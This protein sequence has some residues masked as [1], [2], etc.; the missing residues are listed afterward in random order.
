[1]FCHKTHQLW[2]SFSTLLPAC[3]ASKRRDEFFIIFLSYD[4]NW[5]RLGCKCVS[6]IISHCVIAEC[7]LNMSKIMENCWAGMELCCVLIS[8][9]AFCFFSSILRASGILKWVIMIN[10]SKYICIMLW[11]W[12]MLCTYRILFRSLPARQGLQTQI[13]RGEN[14]INKSNMNSNCINYSTF[15]NSQLCFCF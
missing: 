5:K 7:E 11:M 13:K 12:F 15:N 14:G 1:M 2:C 8:L 9:L 6:I 3:V 4:F 10:Y